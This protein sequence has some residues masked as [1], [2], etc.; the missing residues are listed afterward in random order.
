M[1]DG[2]FESNLSSHHNA[3]TRFLEPLI[4]EIKMSNE[5]LTKVEY[6]CF[7]KNS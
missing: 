7:S 1:E 3:I 5:L 4:D 6:S 2:Q